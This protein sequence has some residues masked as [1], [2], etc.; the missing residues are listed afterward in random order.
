M[1]KAL[2]SKYSDVKPIPTVS[3]AHKIQDTIY[4]V[5]ILVIS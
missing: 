2:P 5:L 4:A 3:F 1:G